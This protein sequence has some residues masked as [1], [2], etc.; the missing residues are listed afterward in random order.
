MDF[1]AVDENTVNFSFILEIC[2][3]KLDI[4]FRRDWLPPSK[5]HPTSIERPRYIMR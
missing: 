1:Q 5:T 4:D 3:L 2:H